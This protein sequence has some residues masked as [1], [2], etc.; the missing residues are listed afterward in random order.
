MNVYHFYGINTRPVYIQYRPKL[1]FICICQILVFTILMFLQISLIYSTLSYFTPLMSTGHRQFFSTSVC[2]LI[3]GRLCLSYVCSLSFLFQ[4]S[5]SELVFL[6]MSNERIS[7]WWQFCIFITCVLS[8]S[9]SLFLS[10]RVFDLFNANGLHFLFCL[11]I[12]SI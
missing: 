4:E 9:F 8:I 11:V 3:V 1:S 7:K 12:L 2:H 10:Q 5:F 6:G